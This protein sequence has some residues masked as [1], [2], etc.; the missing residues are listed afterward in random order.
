VYTVEKPV[1]QTMQLAIYEPVENNFF[2][3]SPKTGNIG[4]KESSLNS[5]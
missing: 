2:Y 1:I 3:S 4:N 5:H